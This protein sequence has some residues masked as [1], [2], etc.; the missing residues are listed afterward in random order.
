[1]CTERP[2]DKCKLLSRFSLERQRPQSAAAQQQVHDAA[3]QQNLVANVTSM[4]R[5]RPSGSSCGLSVRACR[6]LREVRCSVCLMQGRAADSLQACRCDATVLNRHT[7]SMQLE[8][9]STGTAGC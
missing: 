4:W 5:P 8:S 6:A 1:M 3:Q 2:A 9:L 7:L